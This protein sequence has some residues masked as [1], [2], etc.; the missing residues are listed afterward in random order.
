MY[1]YWKE[2]YIKQLDA[3]KFNFLDEMD[4]FLKVYTFFNT[5]SEKTR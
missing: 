3:I 4:E 5:H 2:K 1:S